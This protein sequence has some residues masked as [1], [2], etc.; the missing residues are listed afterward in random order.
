MADEPYNISINSQVQL[1][2]LRELLKELELINSELAKLNYASFSTLTDSAK[3][4]AGVGKEVSS[5][6]SAQKAAL[7]SLPK[8]ADKAADSIQKAGSATKEAAKETERSEQVLTGF[9]MEVGAAASRFAMQLPAALSSSIK[10]FGQQEL[11]TQKLAAAIKAQG[12]SVSEVLPVMQELASTIQQVTTYGDEQVMGMQSMAASMGVTAEQMDGVIKTAIG[13]STALGMDVTTATKAAAAAVQGKTGMLQE[14]IPSLIKCKTEEEKLAKVQELSASG[15]SQAE[16][17]A[18]TLEGK[19]QQA[20][21][22]W[23]DLSEIVGGTFAP[24]IK[25]V[26][27]LITG[28]CQV[29]SENEAITKALTAGLASVAV[30]LAFSK[31][32]GLLNVAKMFLGVASG[33][34]TATTATHAFNLAVKANP[35]G[36]IASAA[37]FAILA[38]TNLASTEDEEAEAQDAATIKRQKAAEETKKASEIINEYE[39]SLKAESATA[40]ELAQ[41]TADKQRRKARAKEKGARQASGR[42]FEKRCGDRQRGTARRVRR[43]GHD[44]I[45]A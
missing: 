41:K 22:A 34:K 15:F 8:A 33:V 9:F 5:A 14:Y 35:I 26:A 40:A 45:P 37:T 25:G 21:N 36:L 38:L 4:F 23:G 11:A 13:L 3:T 44:K 7:D 1:D 6:I 12:G 29:M 16:A 10:A 19:L 39:E 20:A 30:G 24:L 32:G 42:I 28:V 27:G 18:K 2:E 43:F 31:V 17:A